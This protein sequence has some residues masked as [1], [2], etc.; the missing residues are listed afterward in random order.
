[1]LV[2][3]VE[4]R[5][6]ASE[7]LKMKYFDLSIWRNEIGISGM[8]NVVNLASFDTNRMNMYGRRVDRFQ[9]THMRIKQSD[10][11]KSERP[12]DSKK[13]KNRKLARLDSRK[14]VKKILLKTLN[15]KKVKSKKASNIRSRPYYPRRCKKLV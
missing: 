14:A 1:M 11:L 2:A 8:K 4:D 13:L 9:R 5:K 15:N 12:L 7:L 10:S 3:N 6:S